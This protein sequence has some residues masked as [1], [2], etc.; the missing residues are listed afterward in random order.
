MPV[1]NN[2]LSVELVS[3]LNN[4]HISSLGSDGW[5]RKLP[6]DPHH[7]VFDAIRR[8]EEVLHI[9]FVVPGLRTLRCFSQQQAYQYAQNN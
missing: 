3:E 5:P 7:D 8:P 4:H 2:S 9:P 6:V 1:N